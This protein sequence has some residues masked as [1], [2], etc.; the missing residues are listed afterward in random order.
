MGVNYRMKAS[1]FLNSK[2]WELIGVALLFG[3]WA[4]LSV[5]TNSMLLPSPL[6]V[7]G[8]LGKLLSTPSD[9]KDVVVT[10]LRGFSGIGLAVLAGGIAGYAAGRNHWLESL[11]RP[12]VAMMKAVPVV[13]IIILMIFWFKTDLVP[14]I[15][16]FMIA[17]PVVYHGVLQGTRQV[18][19]KLLEMALVFRVPSSRVLTGIYLPS[20]LP[21]LVGAMDAAI[22]IGWKSVIA[23][24]VICQPKYGIGT[25]LMNAKYN[26]VMEPLFAWTLLAVALSYLTEHGIRAL[27]ATMSR[28]QS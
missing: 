21:Y 2:K 11:L 17:F 9:L 14:V 26:L 18:D 13:S 20:L 12:T 27:H 3:G 16:G 25:Q 19:A 1:T 24:E 23:A 7:L 22:G 10:L 8:A 4:A 6:K 15:I 28:W 5:V